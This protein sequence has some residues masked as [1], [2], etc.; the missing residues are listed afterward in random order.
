MVHKTLSTTSDIWR[1]LSLSTVELLWG[2]LLRDSLGLTLM[3]VTTTSSSPQTLGSSELHPVDV[4][5]AI[6]IF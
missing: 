5:A 6:T 4:T 3:K 1:I 2:N